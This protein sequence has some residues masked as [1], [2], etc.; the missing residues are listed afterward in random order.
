M[1]RRKLI[2]ALGAA[3][4]L[5]ATIGGFA[6]VQWGKADRA[7]SLARREGQTD[8]M[9]LQHRF[10]E[11]TLA[12]AE[13]ARMWRNVSRFLADLAH[14]HQMRG[15]VG[16]ALLL[17]LESLQGGVGSNPWGTE[18]LTVAVEGGYGRH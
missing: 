2:T 18:Q 9:N 17:A 14:Q 11:P 8:D 7:G 10:M 6:W 5:M 4:V 15:D 1:K 16:T 3:T 13:F 12:A